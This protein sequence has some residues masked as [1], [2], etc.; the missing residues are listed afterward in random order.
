MGH[1][2]IACFA[3]GYGA[4]E[5]DMIK[6]PYGLWAAASPDRG[7]SVGCAANGAVASGPVD[8]GP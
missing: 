6:M 1:A 3:E 5:R 8:R 2:D 4:S 7:C